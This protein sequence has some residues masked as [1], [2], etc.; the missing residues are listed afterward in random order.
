MGGDR[1]LQV[2]PVLSKNNH[3]EWF[4][5]MEVE[6]QGKGCFY[7]IMESMKEYSLI[8]PDT[9]VA[10]ITEKFEAMQVT[11]GTGTA[12]KTITV[13]HSISMQKEWKMDEAKAIARMFKSLSSED[14]SLKETVDSAKKF[15]HKLRTNYAQTDAVVAE[16]Y[17]GLIQ[18]FNKEKDKTIKETWDKLLDYRRRLKAADIT[19]SGAYSDQML[20]VI[21]VRG[22]T[23]DPKWESTVDSINVQAKLTIEE[24]LKALET[25]EVRMM[26][27]ESAKATTE[28]GALAAWQKGRLA[29]RAGP[30]QRSTTPEQSC[31]LCKDKDHIVMLCPYLKLA[32]NYVKQLVKTVKKQEL[33]GRKGTFNPNDMDIDKVKRLSTP[34]NIKDHAHIA[35]NSDSDSDEEIAN[36]ENL[37]LARDLI[38]KQIIPPSAWAS[39][40]GASSHMSDKSSL[41]RRLE[42]IPRRVIRVGG[43]ELYADKRGEVEMV[44]E[45]GSWMVL[46]EVLLVPELGINLLSARKLCEA[47]ME[48]NFNATHM[49]FTLNQEKVITSIMRNGLYMVSHIH[50]KAQRSC[51]LAF[52]A[53][54]FTPAT[55]AEAADDGELSLSDKQRYELWH[56]RCSHLGPK[57]IRDLHLVT[58]ITKPIKVP[59]NTRVCDT[60]ALTK[61]KDKINRELSE[62]AAEKLELIQCDVA[63]PFPP[64]LG[65]RTYFL[66]IID[67]Y[68]NMDW[69][70]PLKDKAS[71]GNALKQFKMQQEL[72]TGLKIKRARSDNAPELLKQIA[73]WQVEQ[74]TLMESTTVA[75][76][77]Q[78]G[79]PE[80]T[81]QTATADIRALLKDGDLPVEFWD[82]AAEFDSHI[83]NCT[84][85]GPTINGSITS[86][87]Q[88]YLGRKPNMDTTRV[89]GSKCYMYIPRDSIPAKQRTDKLTDRARVGV[90]LGLSKTTS[91]HFKVYS[92][93]L[94]YT[95]RSSHVRVDENTPGGSIDLRFRNGP[96]QG[97]MNSFNDRKPRGRPTKEKTPEVYKTIP[98]VGREF[99]GGDHSEDDAAIR[100]VEELA[101]KDTPI[102]SGA[103]SVVSIPYFVLPADRPSFTEKLEPL[104]KEPESYQGPASER[105]T[106]QPLPEHNPQL[107]PV[108]QHPKHA[109]VEDAIE[110]DDSPQLSIDL[111]VYKK[112][113]RPNPGLEKQK[114]QPDDYKQPR[115][116][117]L[118]L[119]YTPPTTRKRS[120]EPEDTNPRF[121]KLKKPAGDLEQMI[122]SLIARD[123]VGL[124]DLSAMIAKENISKALQQVK[125]EQARCEFAHPAIVEEFN[126][127]FAM[128]A[129][130]IC[131]INIPQSVKEALADPKYRKQW[132]AAMREE[133]ENL[134]ANSTWKVVRT[135][136]G[137]NLVTMKWVFTIKT[138]EDGSFDRFKAR[139]VAR[140]FTQMYGVDY[141]QTFAPTVRMDTFRMFMA[142]AA[143][144]DLE[145]LH[146]DIKNAFTESELAE[147]IYLKAPFGIDIAEGLSLRALR[148]IYGL[149]QAARDWH[150][151]LKRKLLGWGFIQSLA[152]P[153]LFT[154][155]SRGITLLVYVDDIAASA[156]NMSELLWF[157]EK[158][159]GRFKA[160]KLGEIRKI[161]GVRVTRDRK[162]RTIYLDQEQYLLAILQRIGFEKAAF[163]P[164]KVPF[165]DATQL[166]PAKEGDQQAD[167]TNYQMGVGSLMYAMILTRPDLCTIVGKLAQFMSNPSIKHQRALEQVVRYIASTTKLRLRYGPDI[168]SLQDRNAKKYGFGENLVIYTDADWAN[169]KTDRKS[170]SGSVAMIYGGPV[171]WFSKKQKCVA[172]SSCESEYVA[173]CS[174]SKVGVWIRNV[175]KDMGRSKYVGKKILVLG[176]NQGAI[177]LAENPQL[178]ERSK[179]IDVQYHYVR[180]LVEKGEVEINYIPTKDMAADGM[181]K[182][183]LEPK[184]K[185]FKQMM[186]LVED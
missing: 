54:I 175:L 148:S 146:F 131:G 173:Q 124:Q 1:D 31:Y 92:P 170:V 46:K 105:L 169:D 19:A 117:S 20:W 144:E 63:G 3:E 59:S 84:A 58:N 91:K 39:D 49:F 33:S 45:D 145:L 78:N 119:G 127:D 172:T 26:D 32:Q 52:P 67:S 111:S 79:L 71:A 88:A 136:E 181:T 85:I 121:T 16:K 151:L 137:A 97:H 118:P 179:H 2:I 51:E 95:T 83:R 120:A 157:W 48:G 102:T 29:Q 38:S 104:P 152:D 162:S 122:R 8:D 43:G 156:K 10:D 37:Y 30:G 116:A 42:S 40:T 125:E 25:K 73:G 22:L 135:P 161:L 166:T 89:F 134:M 183:L 174:S 98:D 143:K 77:R 28:E 81:I 5:D 65:G 185:E 27:E 103:T 44:C 110:P 74:G 109:T 57:K 23:K 90:Y 171:A 47:G 61:M 164:K 165:V 106:P 133:I 35:G 130:E 153:C 150:T 176:D 70:I 4:R 177:A 41:F 160:K 186:G 126:I 123:I 55:P 94:G 158:L 15:W 114:A 36:T 72:Q 7:T 167:V 56:R 68:T 87:Y 82:E 107:P 154:H 155:P 75:T 99:T 50:N 34:R 113:D 184:Y 132:L 80:R 18:N 6:L 180:E 96:P 159:D 142:I 149:K 141:T 100:D 108:T 14:K 138:K 182:L 12:A 140:G 93:E 9:A 86:P 17:M 147:K 112:D 129:L 53:A 139:L 101:G 115:V 128:P 168:G 69:T 60:C 66:L 21:L 11:K 64:S 24:K 178:H 13:R 163:T 62:R 76:S